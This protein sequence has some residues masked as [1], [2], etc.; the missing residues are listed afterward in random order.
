MLIEFYASLFTSSNP[1][2]LKRILDQVQS[3][4][5]EDMQAYLAKPYTM[6]DGYD[7]NVVS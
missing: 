6:D 2:N 7:S 3:V 4:V 1:C 5:T